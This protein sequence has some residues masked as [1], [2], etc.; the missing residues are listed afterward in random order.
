M[1]DEAIMFAS[2][3]PDIADRQ[4]EA[5]W[6]ARAFAMTVALVDRH[7]FTWKEWAEILTDELARAETVEKS[8]RPSYYQCWLQTL[9][10]A[11]VLTH[12]VSQDSLSSAN[13]EVRTNWPH[14][15]HI[16]Q[17][18]PVAVS[19]RGPKIIDQNQSGI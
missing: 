7:Q 8:V 11:L 17:R 19:R 14:P 18:S 15:V 2:D 12:L 3:R 6:Q 1:T 4:F 5:P 13:A 9:E 16:A 10:R